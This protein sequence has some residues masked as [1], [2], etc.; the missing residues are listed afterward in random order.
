MQT[1]HR[2]YSLV[3]VMAPTGTDSTS[4]AS[5]SQANNTTTPQVT[6]ISEN[7]SI[8]PFTGT[9]TESVQAFIRRINEECTRR[10]STTDEGKIS[11]LKSRICSEPNSLAWKLVKSDK[12]LSLK[13][14]DDF[15]NALTNH[16]AS[17]SKLGVSHSFLKIAQTLS[18]IT[19]STP[20]VYSA[21]NIACSLSSEL[22]EQLQISQWTDENNNISSE[23][24]KRIIAYLI[25]LVQ[26][27]PNLFRIASEIKFNKGDFV[28]DLCRQ[29]AEK[30]PPTAT[31]VTVTQSTS[32][33]HPQ[34]QSESRPQR[35]SESHPDAHQ[36]HPHHSRPSR[37][38]SRN[39]SHG[40]NYHRS[41]SR[42]SQNIICY[43]CNRPGHFASQCR[44]QS[45]EQGVA[46]YNP[47]AFCEYHNKPGHY[48]S[49]CR[50]SRRRAQ[51]QHQSGNAARGNANQ[52]S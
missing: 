40:R 14:Y 22:I 21:E 25:F 30:A 39:H 49:E 47:D 35:Q 10:S 33:A 51:S 23:T 31:L 11:V 7:V 24:L 15:T 42:G 50:A 48:T 27:E 19:R 38:Q 34:W 17:H 3:P 13:T 9:G 6:L 12:F 41:N 18:Y 4:Q 29:M 32:S 5:T 28:Y 2:D 44:T 20:D 36:T 26:L 45:T 37:P 46:Q 43:R 1:R 16:F 8:P 52:S